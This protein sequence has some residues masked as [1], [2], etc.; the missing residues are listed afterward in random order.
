[1]SKKIFKYLI[2]ANFLLFFWQAG[3]S[4]AVSTQGDQLSLLNHQIAVVQ[5]DIDSMDNQLA[6]IYSLPSL[7]Y[8]AQR[9]GFVPSTIVQLSDIK[10]ADAGRK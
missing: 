8:T 6:S 1:M 7:S 10:L 2:V 3:L 5:A 9:L 4:L